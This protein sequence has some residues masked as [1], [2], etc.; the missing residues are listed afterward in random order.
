M[1]LN[2]TPKELSERWWSGYMWGAPSHGK[3]PLTI[4]MSHRPQVDE[5]KVIRE[6]CWGGAAEV[7]KIINASNALS[8]P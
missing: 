8:A 5:M 4:F 3:K 7:P 2:A 1:P 6:F